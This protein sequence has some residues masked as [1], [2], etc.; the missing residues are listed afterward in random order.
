MSEIVCCKDLYKTYGSVTA[1]N[2][3][4]FTLESGKI[5]GLLVPTVPARP[6]L[7]SF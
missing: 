3:V 1:L 2:N 5:V 6:P 7:L 4:N